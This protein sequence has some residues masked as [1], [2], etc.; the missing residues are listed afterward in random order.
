VLGRGAAWHLVSYLRRPEFK[1][2]FDEVPW[3][4]RPSGNGIGGVTAWNRKAMNLLPTHGN[5]SHDM[6]ED[7]AVVVNRAGT[8]T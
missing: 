3:I 7:K 2:H 8:G 1:T 4:T 5:P 6:V